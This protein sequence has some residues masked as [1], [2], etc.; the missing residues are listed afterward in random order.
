M[1]VN[2][3]EV[4]A[5]EFNACLLK[6]VGKSSDAREQVK[7]NHV[8]PIHNKKLKKPPSGGSVNHIQQGKVRPLS[9]G[10]SIS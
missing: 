8:V 4:M 7:I 10:V 1:F 5:L 6:C 2:F 3:R 9:G